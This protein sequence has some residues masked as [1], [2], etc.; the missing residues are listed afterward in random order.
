[1]RT[2]AVASV[3][4]LHAGVVTD[5]GFFGA[6]VGGFVQLALGRSGFDRGILGHEASIDGLWLGVKHE[7]DQRVTR[8]LHPLVW[9]RVLWRG[10]VRGDTILCT[11]KRTPD[12]PE[13]D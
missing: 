8:R 12:E 7:N 2:R 4:H 13:R 1:M 3:Q 11:G 6:Q 9:V 10:S 5:A